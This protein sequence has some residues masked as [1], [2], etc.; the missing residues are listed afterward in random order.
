MELRRQGKELIGH[1]SEELM[2]L[3]KKMVDLTVKI[4]RRQFCQI[5]YPILKIASR[6]KSITNKD[7]EF[8]ANQNL[9]QKDR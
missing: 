3:I 2:T 5:K 9:N 7:L 1:R 4:W 6:L 8:Y